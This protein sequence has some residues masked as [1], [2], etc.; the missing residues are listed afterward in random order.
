LPKDMD[1]IVVKKVEDIDFN[2]IEKLKWTNI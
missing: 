2:I 1:T